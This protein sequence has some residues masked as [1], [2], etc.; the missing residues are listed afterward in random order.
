[1]FIAVVN[2]KGGVGKSTLAV[3][4]ATWLFDRGAKVALIDCPQLLAGAE[5]IPGKSLI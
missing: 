3:H 4:L 5:R 1:M 2:E